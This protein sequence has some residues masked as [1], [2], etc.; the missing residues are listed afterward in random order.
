MFLGKLICLFR[1]HKY[2]LIGSILLDG[3]LRMYRVVGC[4]VCDHVRVEGPK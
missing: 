4:L 1:G 2:P 3:D